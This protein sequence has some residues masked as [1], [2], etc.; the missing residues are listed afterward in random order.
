MS[1]QQTLEQKRAAAAWDCIQD[2]VR[3]RDTALQEK[4]KTLAI[5]A[6]ADIQTNGLGQTIAF[7][8]AKGAVE[9]GK[10]P[11]AEKL[12]HQKILAHL[13][14]WLKSAE[15]L[16]LPT[17]NLVEWVSKT[18]SA[19][20]YRRATTEAIAFLVWLKRFAE[21]ELPSGEFLEKQS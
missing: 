20:D 21:A 17:D 8:K 12:A 9:P 4:Y 1:N 18:A 19:D 16:Q 6:T 13:T 10:S 11:G 14:T 5:K 15:T 7:W 2:I 3:R